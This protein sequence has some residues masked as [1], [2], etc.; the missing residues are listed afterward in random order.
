MLQGPRPYRHKIDVLE[1]LDSMP[2]LL[3]DKE[4]CRMECKLAA[5]CGIAMSDQVR[6]ARSD[7]IY[8][9]YTVSGLHQGGTTS[10]VRM[11][12]VGRKKLESTKPLSA[13]DL[14]VGADILRSDLSDAQAELQSEFVERLTDDGVHTGLVAL[15]PHGGRI[16]LWTDQQAEHVATQ[17][18]GKGVSSWRCKGWH[19][20]GSAYD[21][22]HIDASRISRNSFPLLD[23]IGDRGFTYAV[24]FHGWSADGILIGGGAPLQLKQDIRDAIIAAINDVSI[25]VSIADVN[26]FYN[27]DNPANIVNWLTAGGT[28]GIQLEQS[29]VARSNYWQP[30]A[31]AVASVFEPLI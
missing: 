6:L 11:G 10:H 20:G 2:E 7:G 15:A 13:I 3:D 5:D 17:L 25:D 24:C 14:F 18:L 30:I 28:G 19:K 31:E 26:E 16:E 22:W 12:L 1:A 29:A 8:A 4:L 27:G 23:S 9:L 21:R